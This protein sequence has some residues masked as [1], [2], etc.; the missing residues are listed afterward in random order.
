MTHI[1]IYIIILK[2]Y[3]YG[4]GSFRTIIVT[5]PSAGHMR[6][7]FS[8]YIGPGPGDPRWG[9]ESLKDPNTLAID[10]LL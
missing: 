9:R 4:I 3:R 1:Y 8:R 10:V 5:V 7:E 6:G 2:Y